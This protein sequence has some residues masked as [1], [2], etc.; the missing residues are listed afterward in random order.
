MFKTIDGYQRLL[1]GAQ[2]RP[3]ARVR[4]P[5]LTWH[6][7]FWHASGAGDTASPTPEERF[8]TYVRDICERAKAKHP[9]ADEAAFGPC[10]TSYEKDPA[11]DDHPGLIVLEFDWYFFRAIVRFEQH[12]EYVTISVLL[13]LSSE[14]GLPIYCEAD[15][16]PKLCAIVDEINSL[17]EMRMDDEARYSV[18]FR[19][20][21]QG[22]SQ[23]AFLTVWEEFYD[24]VLNT[25]PAAADGFGK[26]FADFR[27]IVLSDKPN[28]DGSESPSFFGVQLPFWRKPK[29]R[30]RRLSRPPQEP[31]TYWKDRYDIL[32]PLMTAK[33]GD[34]DFLNY[35][36]T[37]SMMGDGRALYL[38][39]LGAQP[40]KREPGED[41]I[42]L[43]YGLY[44]HE[45]GGWAIGRLI[46]Q[47]NQQGTL[48][49]A[50]LIELPALQLAAAFLREAES[51][52]RKAYGSGLEG[53][54]EDSQLH[55]RRREDRDDRYSDRRIGELKGCLTR[56][57]L[58]L[59]QAETEVEGGVERRIERSN[60]Y[61]RRFR[62]GLP[63]LVIKPF[64]DMQP[65][66][67]FVDRRL[68]PTF[69]YIDMLGSR[70]GRVRRDLRTLYQRVL[71]EETKDVATAIRDRNTETERI[72]K[73]AE[74]ALLSFIGPY[75]VGMI[76]THIGFPEAEH[77]MPNGFWILLWA[78]FIIL[79]C[80]RWPM[81]ERLRS[82]LVAVLTLAAAAFASSLYFEGSAELDWSRSDIQV[83]A[84]PE[85]ERSPAQKSDVNSLSGEG[86]PQPAANVSET[87]N[88]GALEPAQQ[89]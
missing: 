21:F 7:G 77:G 56:A 51:E 11:A 60:Y 9:N 63:A 54:K 82:A 24:D 16:P 80:A 34:V 35:E 46:E 15:V 57:Q 33:M 8:A 78:F 19:H 30:R 48:R 75:Y 67:V 17:K 62:Q 32:W 4:H 43:C 37:A 73:F 84:P 76:V 27:G 53:G 12:T 22:I 14:E 52:V 45:L 23:A 69:G 40:V 28:P 89:K 55:G 3:S 61:I 5:L 36:F 29:T 49:L 59:S 87:G 13:D 65:Y 10:L 1:A 71:A 38:S 88:S 72:H 74:F 50:S 47:I 42:P 44:T 18:D 68:G 41:R 25:G 6:L 79:A 83:T 86:R 31:D 2:N 81:R 70:Y 85:R 39:A 64:G 58:A 20:N 26:V 66:D